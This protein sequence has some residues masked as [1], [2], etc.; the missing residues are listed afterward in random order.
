M[1]IIKNLVCFLLVIFIPVFGGCGKAAL[2]PMP[3][4]T[5][6]FFHKAIENAEELS[7]ISPY[8]AVSVLSAKNDLSVQ[9][10]YQ[11]TETPFER[12][13]NYTTDLVKA[14]YLTTKDMETNLSMW[15]N[16]CHIFEVIETVSGDTIK[17]ILY[18]QDHSYYTPMSF[19]KGESYLLLLRRSRNVYVQEDLFAFASMA[20]IPLKAN[21]DVDIDNAIMV[22]TGT[23]LK[24]IIVDEQ[25]KEAVKTGNFINQIVEMLK[26]VHCDIPEDFISSEDPITILKSSPHIVCVTVGE[27]DKNIYDHF[28]MERY[29]CNVLQNLKGEIKGNIRINLPSYTVEEG[30]QYVIALSDVILDEA[31]GDIYYKPSSQYSIFNISQI[32]LIKNI[33]KKIV[34]NFNKS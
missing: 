16:Y 3:I 9:P 19:K 5:V 1:K 22:D 29:N 6:E 30:K 10:C 11:I 21:K 17:S 25:L 31:N 32:Q 14:T 2:I 12:D 27:V 34:G 33:T 24:D 20:R 18:V 26:S 28:Y 23:A 13:L 8:S 4:Y 7:T 15:H